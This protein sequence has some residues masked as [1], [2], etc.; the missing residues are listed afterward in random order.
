[1]IVNI[2][3]ADPSLTALLETK[4]QNSTFSEHRHAAYQ[5]KGNHQMK[6]HGS[7]YF[8]RGTL[9]DP[10]VGIKRSKFNLFRTWSC[11]ISN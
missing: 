11:C 4:G 3:P 5:I 7:K 2:L 10:A 9:S 8:A 1:M 6:Q